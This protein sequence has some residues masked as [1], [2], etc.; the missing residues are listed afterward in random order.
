MFIHL[1]GV[2]Y[3]ARHGF[4]PQEQTVGAYF[5]VDLRLKTDFSRAAQTDELEGTVSYAEV[6]EV[7]K[8]VMAQPSRL[9][10]HV[11]GRIAQALFEH[12]PQV[13]E[14]SVRVNKENPPMGAEAM[15]IGVEAVFVRKRPL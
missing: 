15:E 11:C 5:T 13:E 4:L 3:Y 9:L 2:R 10:E 12:F 6:Y 7:V 1:R 8:E 14:V